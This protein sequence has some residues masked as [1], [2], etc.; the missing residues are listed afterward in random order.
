MK[1]HAR[2][3][4]T[5]IPFL[6]AAFAGSAW[7]QD[8]RLRYRIS[9]L[10][11]PAPGTW[12][13][14]IEATGLPTRKTDL[15]WTL[16]DWG[17]W[18]GIRD[19]FFVSLEA[20]PPLAARQP[21][22]E[23]MFAVK[24]PG[25]WDG[26]ASIGYEITLGLDGTERQRE[27]GLLPTRCEGRASGFAQS[28]LMDLR[29][30]GHVVDAR[31]TIELIAPE[32]MSVVTGWGGCTEGRQVVEI[33]RPIDSC[34]IHFAPPPRSARAEID[35][36]LY[37]VFQFEGAKDVTEGLLAFA[38]TFVPAVAEELDFPLGRPVRIYV[39]SG[40]GGMATDHGLQVG[41]QEN[42][43]NPY[44]VNLLAHETFHHWLPGP[45]ERDGQRIVWFHEGFCDYLALWFA[46]R[47]GLISQAW[48][49][50]RLLEI[51]Q[52][53]RASPSFGQV[54]LDDDEVV[55]RDGDGP[56]ETLAYKGGC[57]LAFLIDAELH[58]KRQDGLTALM[59]FLLHDNESRY[60]LRAFS[61]WMREH[62]LGKLYSDHVAGKQ[63]WP[64]AR[65][66]LSRLGF[67]DVG[68]EEEVYLTYTGVETDKGLTPGKVLAIDPDGPQAKRDLR[69]GDE[70]LTVVSPRAQE[71]WMKE[72]LEYRFAFGLTTVSTSGPWFVDVRRNGKRLRVEIEP[73]LQPGGRAIV[74]RPDR[75]KVAA[76]FR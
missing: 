1:Q 66:A 37:E 42:V 4:L 20:D 8:A 57:L 26:R 5:V 70:I 7:A 73:W 12:K 48:F 21:S 19:E 63:D 56:N 68:A 62:R 50:E 47:C 38:R 54:R 67:H 75:E 64:D 71:V 65:K 16:H 59:R 10:P 6:L 49:S 60:S 76:F 22:D 72:G 17:G 30:N 13:V 34:S 41:Y 14:E 52:A 24:I 25:R 29:V 23:T 32:G 58:A 45:M 27:H 53:A 11:D 2:A 28:A 15:E 43:H 44:Y 55:W 61:R 18:T 39:V 51:E 31:R 46:A 69:V 40:G 35:G 74:L 9:Y 33:D 36:A 3:R